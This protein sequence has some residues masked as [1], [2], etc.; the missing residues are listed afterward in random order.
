[1]KKTCT[2]CKTDKDLE[3]FKKGHSWCKVCTREKDRLWRSKN[4]KHRMEY[5]KKRR[6][7]GLDSS[8]KSEEAKSRATA[9]LRK[10][11]ST[12][13]DSYIIKLIVRHEPLLNRESLK[14]AS[15]LIELKRK[16]LTLK[17]KIYGKK[18]ENNNSKG[19]D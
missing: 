10:A 8:K 16:E 19:C 9:K 17:R 7:L 1:M 13:T 2:K 3:D 4:V 15:D 12:L 5:K 11:V 18:G 14:E 6:T